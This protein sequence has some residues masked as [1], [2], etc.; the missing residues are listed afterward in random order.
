MYAQRALAIARRRLSDLLADIG[1]HYPT[2]EEAELIEQLEREID[3]A[4]AYVED[5]AEAY[6]DD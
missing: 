1:A 5:H 2:D 3:E 6:S 4:E